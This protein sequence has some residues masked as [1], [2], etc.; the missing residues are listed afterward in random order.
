M[1][2]ADTDTLGMRSNAAGSSGSTWKRIT[3]DAQIK[4]GAEEGIAGKE[5][6]RVEMMRWV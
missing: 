4:G 2:S 5:E 6:T 3:D 1:F